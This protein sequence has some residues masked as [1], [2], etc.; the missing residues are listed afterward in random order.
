MTP[1]ELAKF[2]HETYEAIAWEEGWKTQKKSRVHWSKLPKEN[3]AT[4]LRVAE[5]VLGFVPC[6]CPV[7]Q[8]GSLMNVV[9]R[10]MP[11]DAIESEH[12][13]GDEQTP[14]L[15]CTNCHAFY[16]FSGFQKRGRRK[17]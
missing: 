6:M 8:C 16:K 10:P 7:W 17:S 5:E 12:W 14:D 15:V 13:D 11:K 2:M 4:M 1:K 3:K 9:E